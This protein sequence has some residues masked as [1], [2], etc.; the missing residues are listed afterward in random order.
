[1]LC[2]SSNYAQSL[3]LFFKFIPAGFVFGPRPQHCNNIIYEPYYDGVH[4]ST[5]SFTPFS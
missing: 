2:G 1:M 4:Y 3:A 5:F